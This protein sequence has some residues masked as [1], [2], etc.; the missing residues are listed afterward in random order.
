MKRVT[1]LIR[2]VLKVRIKG[3]TEIYVYVY[4]HDTWLSYDK[5]VIEG[6]HNCVINI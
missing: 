2:S 5:C 3:M 4:D 6:S 1:C